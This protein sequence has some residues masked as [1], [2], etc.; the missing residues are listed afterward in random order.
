[1]SPVISFGVCTSVF[2]DFGSV[3][4]FETLGELFGTNTETGFGKWDDQN[5]QKALGKVLLRIR[6]GWLFFSGKQDGMV[7]A[8]GNWWILSL[9]V[10]RGFFGKVMGWG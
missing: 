10:D 7:N 6:W 5:S 3:T 9:S 8:E 4:F 2:S 1:M